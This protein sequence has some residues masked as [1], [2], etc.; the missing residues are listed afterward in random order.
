MLEVVWVADWEMQCCGVPFS[1]GQK[2]EWLLSTEDPAGNEWLD[3]VLGPDQAARVTASY[4]HHSGGSPSEQT[5]VVRAI[6]AVHCRYRLVGN[7][8]YVPVDGSG[9]FEARTSATGWEDDSG[10]REERRFVG[11]LVELDISM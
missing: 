6:N 7:K 3:A 8:T 1:V 5:G 11:Y 4:D 2:V 10:R 9:T